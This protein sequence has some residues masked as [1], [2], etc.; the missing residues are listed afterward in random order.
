MSFLESI[1]KNRHKSHSLQKLGVVQ[2]PCDVVLP[3]P[4]PPPPPVTLSDALASPTPLIG[5][6]TLWDALADPP[7]FNHELSLEYSKFSTLKPKEGV[8]NNK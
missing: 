2:R 4:R 7:T 6:M 5:V 3:H 8:I 1:Y